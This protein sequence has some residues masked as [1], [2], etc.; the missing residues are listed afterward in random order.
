MTE[1]KKPEPEKY[2]SITNIGEDL[3]TFIGRIPIFA[4]PQ[5]VPNPADYLVGLDNSY[6]PKIAK[7]EYKGPNISDSA[8]AA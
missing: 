7:E 6:S 8:P 1:N 2:L 3:A 5:E 4:A